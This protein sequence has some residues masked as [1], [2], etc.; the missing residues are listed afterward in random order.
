MPEADLD[1]EV[2]IAIARSIKTRG[3]IPTIAAVAAD[4][5]QDVATVDA[6]FA[7]LIEGRVFIPRRDSHEIYSYNPFCVEPTDFFVT[8][9]VVCGSGSAPGTRSASQRRLARRA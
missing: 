5:G 8:A 2:R 3:K 1:R 4:M 9:A 7:R 6:A